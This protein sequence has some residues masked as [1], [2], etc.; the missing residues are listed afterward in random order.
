M[1]ILLV[2]DDGPPGNHSPFIIQ[3]AL[4]LTLLGHELVVVL[5]DSQKS[6]ISKGFDISK[7]VSSQIY[8]PLDPVDA[9]QK[10]WIL[11]D[12]T[13]AACVNIALNHICPEVDLVISGPNL[14]RNAGNGSILSSG[15]VGAALEAVLLD[16]KAISIS[17]AYFDFQSTKDKAIIE[18]CCE[19]ACKIITDLWESWDTE[20]P[21]MFNI[22]IPMTLDIKGIEWCGFESKSYSS[23]FVRTETGFK[24]KPS[25]T[26]PDQVSVGTDMWAILNQKVS[27]TPM[28]AKYHIET[29]DVAR[30]K[31]LKLLTNL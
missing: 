18:K 17:F 13:P 8:S 12:S 15:T 2:N 21:P 22:N 5:P 24:F 30:F 14:G 25:F 29:S 7:E 11:L 4:A 1:K 26:K 28:H 19:T 27:I 9:S 23:L 31:D 16:R 6:W 10:D 3:F 20:F